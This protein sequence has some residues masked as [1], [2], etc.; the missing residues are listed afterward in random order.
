MSTI[1]TIIPTDPEETSHKRLTDWPSDHATAAG[2]SF[3]NAPFALE[4]HEDGQVV[5][6]FAGYRLYGWLFVR[7]LAVAPSHRGLGLGSRLLSE[8]EDKARAEGM[9]GIF[10]DTYGFQAPGFY[11]RHGYRTFGRLG[12]P[13]PARV[14]SYLAKSLSDSAPLDL[15]R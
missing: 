9:L 5:A 12:H 8:A 3:D 14:R 7:F 10:I 13:D 15:P 6:G 1:R 4:L 2:H 11:E